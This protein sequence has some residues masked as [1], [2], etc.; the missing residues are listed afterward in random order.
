MG[1]P[2]YN[3]W[4]G[5][6]RDVRGT[7]F[8]KMKMHEPKPGDEC[9]I[10][11]QEHGPVS[12]SYHAEDYGPT[13][14]EYVKGCRQLCPRCHGMIHSRFRFPNLWQRYKHKVRT[15]NYG[16]CAQ[17]ANLG[18]FFGYA[19]YVRDIEYYEPHPTGIDWLDAYPVA[20][21]NG[22]PKIATTIMTTGE[23]VHDPL[24][25]GPN[26][27]SLSGVVFRNGVATP[28]EWSKQQGLF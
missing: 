14:Q 8:Y 2:S 18:A 5:L 15:P 28:Y 21:Y 25:Y 6:I 23:E 10:C 26:V 3:G 24:V 13:W 20:P 17:F 11:G 12:L 1:S 16:D 4:A 22:P 27:L 19:K 7:A 9:A